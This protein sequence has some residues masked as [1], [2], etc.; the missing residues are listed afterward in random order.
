MSVLATFV[1]DNRDQII[2]TW[3]AAAIEALALAADDTPKLLNELPSFIDDLVVSLREGIENANHRG[4]ARNHG[5]QRKHIG[6]D[7][8]GLAIEFALITT[9]ILRLAGAAGLVIPEDD[10][11]VMLRTIAQG[12]EQSVTEYAALRDREIAEQAARH[13]SFIA[14][15]LRTPLHNARFATTLIESDIG[16]PRRHLE[17]VARAL[18]QVAEIVDGSLVAARL[19]INPLPRYETLAV[20]ELVAEALET[21]RGGAERRRIELEA[22]HPSLEL[23]ADRKLLGSVL[24]NLVANGVKFSRPGHSVRVRVSEVEDRLRFEIADG[25]GGMPD[26]LPGRLFQPYAQEG[27]DRSGFGLG[28]M[29]VKQAVEAHGGTIRVDNNPGV[30]CCF[31]VDLPR[32]RLL[33]P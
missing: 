21:C 32:S 18:E 33:E 23:E 19:R 20:A 14:H 4:S 8:G 6:L 16:D 5:R 31:I 3:Q 15:E 10:M 30:G 1:E 7:I 24:V 2:A 9:A 22:D 28:L 26:D 27:A 13:Y 25:C 11:V 12:T 29:I 17:R